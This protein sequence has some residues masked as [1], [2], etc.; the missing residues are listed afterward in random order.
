MNCNFVVGQKVVCV[1]ASRSDTLE[2]GRI[3]TV[4]GFDTHLSRSNLT[5]EMTSLGL[6]LVEV[7]PRLRKSYD[8]IRFRPVVTRKTDISIFTAM[9][10]EQK[11]PVNA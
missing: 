1:D 11:Q 5:G 8:A 6:H 7:R 10:T 3:Y 2:K 9:L 4:K